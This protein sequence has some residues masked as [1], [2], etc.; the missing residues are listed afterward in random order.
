[1][2]YWNEKRDSHVPVWNNPR[3]QSYWA[4]RHEINADGYRG[5][6]LQKSDVV[7]V[8]A[9]DVM[10]NLVDGSK[11]WPEMVRQAKHQDQ[12]LIALGTVAS[13]LPSMIRRLHSFIHH[14]GAPKTVY[15]AIPRFD[16]YEHVTKD[17]LCYNVSTRG[18]TPRYCTETGLVPTDDGRM[19]SEQIEFNKRFRHK[20]EL[21][22]LIEERFAFL[23]MMCKLHK[24][25][26]HWSFNPSDASIVSLYECVDMFANISDFMK[27]SF[28]GLIRVQDH[29]FD[30]S[31]GIETHAALANQFMQPEVW[32]FNKLRDTA[33]YNFNWL[34]AQYG[35][36]MIKD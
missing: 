21:R 31:I 17:G 15:M 29:Q 36:S 5:D 25:E 2:T 22:Y 11:R 9:C 28:T 23:E 20:E 12:P 1:M 3:Y 26:L 34:K 18:L 8:G 32:D 35:D 13:G 24:I 16:G 30:R 6:P 27:A 7:Y 4:I 33:E 14:H 19:W 10:T